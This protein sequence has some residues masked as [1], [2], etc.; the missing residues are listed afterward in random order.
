MAKFS[1][2]IEVAMKGLREALEDEVKYG[3]A[4]VRA[5]AIKKTCSAMVL[6][7]EDFAIKQFISRIKEKGRAKKVTGLKP[8]QFSTEVR[9]TGF[10]PPK[11]D[12]F[13]DYAEKDA[14]V[15]SLMW[16]QHYVNNPSPHDL[17]MKVMKRRD[18]PARETLYYTQELS[19]DWLEERLKK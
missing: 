4:F 8:G 12:E 2:M 14:N 17:E 13:I 11:Q 3:D 19:K 6:Y 18:N 16:A 5:E 9:P 1:K 7:D 10:A 15:T